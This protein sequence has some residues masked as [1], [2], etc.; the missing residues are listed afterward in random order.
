MEI[1]IGTD[2]FYFGISPGSAY[3][4]SLGKRQINKLTAKV[5]KL[6]ETSSNEQVLLDEIADLRAQLADAHELIKCCEF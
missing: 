4:Y 5:K 3:T 1:A 6:S 2:F